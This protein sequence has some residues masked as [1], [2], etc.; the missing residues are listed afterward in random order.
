MIAI[1]LI[2]LIRLRPQTVLLFG[3]TLFL[4]PRQ[5]SI[6]L[7]PDEVSIRIKAKGIAEIYANKLQYLMLY[8]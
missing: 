6:Q 8:F 3:A 5:T 1:D 2:Y 4:V 7:M